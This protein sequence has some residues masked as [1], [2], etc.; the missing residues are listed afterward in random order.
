VLKTTPTHDGVARCW[1][2]PCS[3]F[4]YPALDVLCDSSNGVHASVHGMDM[5]LDSFTSK[6]GYGHNFLRNIWIGSLEYCCC[7]ALHGLGQSGMC[8]LVGTK[9]IWLSYPWWMHEYV[10]TQQ[11]KIYGSTIGTIKL[12]HIQYLNVSNGR[13][14]LECGFLLLMAV[15]IKIGTT[16]LVWTRGVK[17]ISLMQIF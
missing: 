10:H 2:W 16:L 14:S 11:M 9:L 8:E 17:L 3:M 13:K 4:F 15:D 12:E 1:Y 5:M 6:D 7:W